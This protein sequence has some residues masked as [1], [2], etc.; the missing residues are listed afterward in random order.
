MFT[1]KKVTIRG[2]RGF[3]GD[4]EFVFDRVATLLYGENRSCKSSTLNAIEWALFGEQCIGKQTNIRERIGWPVGNRHMRAP[5]VVVEVELESEAGTCCVRRSLTKTSKKSQASGLELRLPGGEVVTG[6]KAERRLAQLLGSSFRDFMAVVYQHQE[7][8]RSVLTEEPRERNDALDRLLGL[9][10]YR[11]LL[12]AVGAARVSAWHKDLAGRFQAFQ[13]KVETAI[14]S[15]ANDLAERRRE[16]V[17]NGVAVEHLNET[18]VLGLARSIC[19]DLTAFAGEAGLKA[20][21]VEVP[22][23]W[24]ELSEFDKTISGEINR[25]RGGL[26]DLGEQQELFRQQSDL[27]RLKGDIDGCRR[28]L[29]QVDQNIRQMDA[30]HG[31]RQSVAAR[32]VAV[33]E[34]QDQLH[35]QLRQANAR[36]ALIQEAIACLEKLDAGELAGR[37]PVCDGPA[38]DLLSTLRRQWEDSLQA[39]VQ[40]TT[41]RLESLGSR[42]SELEKVS[43][44]YQSWDERRVKLLGQQNEL[45]QQLA[46]RLGRPRADNQDLS[47]LLNAELGRI[48]SRLKQLADGVRQK[49][50]RLDKVSEE[51]TRIRSIREILQLEQKKKSLEGIRQS[52][53]YQEVQALLDRATQ[54]VADIES[55][56]SAISTVANQEGKTRLAAAACGID[57]YFRMLTRHPAVTKIRLDLSTDGRTGRNVYDLT[58]QDGNDLTPLLSQGDLNA[59]ALAVFLGLACSGEGAAKFGFIVMDDPSQS[60]GCEHKERLIAALNEVTASKQLLLATMD[61]ELRDTW[62]EALNSTKAEYWFEFWTPEHGP[63]ITRQ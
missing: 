39:Q 34:E 10:D 31:G 52:R 51:L 49:Q 42:L 20:P 12:G 26:P 60:L 40:Q 6:E 13:E 1:L 24:A 7:V 15:R 44:R 43:G 56:K 41:E 50:V 37:C 55:I 35:Q 62:R 18:A 27:T 33:Q 58:D 25:L 61:R 53:E 14:Q 8:I 29:E 11:D 22:G 63:T 54:A 2:F 5:D 21:A 38:P 47:A 57:H 17:Q 46:E 3:R 30:E 48:D 9:A 19:Q 45:G 32:V 59:L 23:R 36:A 16:A 28:D 4:E